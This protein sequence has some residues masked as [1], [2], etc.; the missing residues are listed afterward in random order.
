MFSDPHSG[1]LPINKIEKAER[2]P[3]HFDFLP[4]CQ[5][6]SLI[7][8]FHLPPLISNSTESFT[9]EGDNSNGPKI[10]EFSSVEV[11]MENLD[12]LEKSL[13]NKKQKKRH[14]TINHKIQSNCMVP[15]TTTKR[16]MKIIPQMPKWN[17]SWSSPVRSRQIKSQ[18]MSPRPKKMTVSPS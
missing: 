11:K 17:Q 10:T 7:Q 15:M 18:P 12:A 16:E 8:D 5:L 4:N 3:C 1:I 13:Q 6:I 9:M 14:G 2:E